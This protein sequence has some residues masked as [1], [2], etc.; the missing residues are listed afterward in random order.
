M[1]VFVT[2][3]RGYIGCRL[4]EV[5][6][7]AGHEVT[8]C[9]LGLFAGCEWEPLVPPDRE[10]V[11]D[12]RA[13]VPG[14]LEGHDCVMHLAALSN[15]PMGELDPDL[16]SSTNRDGTEH[17]ALLARDAGVERF[18][19]AG[20]CSVYGKA[21]KPAMTETDPPSPLSAYAR[22]KVEAEAL[23]VELATEHFV[24]VLLR[25]ATAF[26]HS[27]MLRVDV[28]ANNLLAC[29]HATGSIRIMSDGSPWRPL[30]HC[31]DIAR[32]FLA[33]ATVPAAV[34]GGRAINVGGNAQ[35]Y[36]VRDIADVVQRLL[37]HAEVEYT[38]EV[39]D[40]PRSYRVSFDLLGELL[41]AFR[42]EHTLESGLE[43]LLR[44]LR[45]HGFSRADWEGRQFVRM[46][47][48]RDRLHLLTPATVS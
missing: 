31:R 38:G 20:S 40:D 7:E 26:G 30:I 6:K 24:P 33:V 37:P 12:V 14:D 25:N 39:G 45:L 16:T 17:V 4:V 28:V 46:R 43:E 34:V 15:D 22:S 27:P 13:L 19:F 18:L 5:L 41:P 21:A 9:D 23:L 3:H 1:K 44:K 29:A 42:L 8:G 47:A 32:A 11:R 48:L 35:N 2:G 10:L 36:R